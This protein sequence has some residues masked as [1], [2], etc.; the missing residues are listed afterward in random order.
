MLAE[1]VKLEPTMHLL[2]FFRND[3]LFYDFT[4]NLHSP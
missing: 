1:Q 3:N 2:T 4:L